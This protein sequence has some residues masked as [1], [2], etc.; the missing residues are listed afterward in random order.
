MALVTEQNTLVERLKKHLIN[1][2]KDGTDRQTIQHYDSRIG[3]IR[4]ISDK[5]MENHVVIHQSELDDEDKY[6]KEDLCDQ[7]ENE[8]IDILA[9]IQTKRDILSPPILANRCTLRRRI[10]QTMP[11][12]ARRIRLQSFNQH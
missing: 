7:F 10:K 12:R 6:F 8:F 3:K 9:Q 4:E 1:F 5:F 11:H 2:K